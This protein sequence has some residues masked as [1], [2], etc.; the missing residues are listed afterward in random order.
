MMLADDVL[1]DLVLDVAWRRN[2]CDNA[3]GNVA[4]AFFLVDQVRPVTGTAK[5]PFKV[6]EV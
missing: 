4:A 3:L 5:S 2:V 6:D 1:V